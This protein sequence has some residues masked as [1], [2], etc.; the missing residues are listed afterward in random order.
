MPPT[1]DD[2]SGEGAEPLVYEMD[3]W[4][5]DERAALGL[6]LDG[7][8]IVHTWE[9][10]ELLVPDGAEEL[11]DEFLDRIEFP[12]ALAEADEGDLDDEAVYAVMSELYLAADRLAGA[13][14]LNVDEAGVFKVI[15]D[16]A[17]LTPPPYGV[18][19]AVWSRVQHLASAAAVA[20]EAEAD[21]EV[22]RRDIIALRDVLRGLV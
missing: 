22:V 11:V 15:A 9:G 16:N 1:A 19:P 21:D 6:L 3:G 20:L 2:P 7:A 13:N 12:D 4:E 18:E 17:S 8:G 10:D 14:V 5:E